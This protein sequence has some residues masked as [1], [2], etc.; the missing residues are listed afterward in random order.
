MSE[1][2]KSPNDSTHQSNY[3]ELQ[4]LKDLIER[5]FLNINKSKYRARS[6][7]G[8]NLKKE[9][10]QD[11]L[12]RFET[13]LKHYESIIT[14]NEW[15]TLTDVFDILKSKVHNSIQI[16]NQTDILQTQKRRSS[17][18]SIYTNIVIPRN[19]FDTEENSE[20]INS[21][22]TNKE[23]Q[24]LS[25][26]LRRNSGEEPEDISSDTENKPNF[27]EQIENFKQDCL[28]HSFHFQRR[29]HRNPSIM[30]FSQLMAFQCIPTF[31]GDPHELDPFLWQIDLFAAQ[32][33]GGDIKPLLNV[34]YL[35]LKG[36]AL[37]KLQQITADTWPEVK[38]KL[39]N[40]FKLERNSYSIMKEVETLLQKND[41]SFDEYKSRAEDLFKW[42]ENEGNYA[43]SSLR[44]HF[45]GGLKNKGLAQAGKSQRDK[46]FPELLTWLK[47]ECEDG[48]EIKEIHTRAETLNTT[49]PNNKFNI[50]RS[51]FNSS[52]RNFANQNNSPR[53]SQFR[54]NQNNGNFQH[55]SQQNAQRSYNQN[56]NRN[57]PR[58]NFNQNNTPNPSLQ[59]RYYYEQN[60]INPP[61]QNQNFQGNNNGNIPYHARNF[62]NESS[63]QR[64]YRNNQQALE[65]NT[66]RGNTSK[67]YQNH[68]VSPQNQLVRYRQQKN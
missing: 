50:P 11:S 2:N 68:Q 33:G 42:V 12:E 39:K 67:Q 22:F 66:P 36:K 64:L 21:S 41:E 26:T 55:N 3:S 24:I 58:N 40:E 61:Q 49:T 48:D 16:L 14:V 45:L 37:Q 28:E 13:I 46:S 52:S 31:E 9:L 5:E 1:R 20:E 56:L 38:D 27:K 34:V 18:T 63:P 7:A 44:K 65:Y 47:K 62:N 51:K 4:Y 59:G 30:E 25:S 54:Q 6:L 53:N 29:L 8:I 32:V 23:N 15:N 10:L 60:N 35:K 19:F 17:E 43:I 57:L